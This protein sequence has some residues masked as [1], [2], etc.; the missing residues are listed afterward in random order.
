MIADLR[1]IVDEST[2]SAVVEY[3]QQLGYDVLFAG[4]IMARSD[5]SVILDLAVQQHRIVVT[6]DKDFG[7]L[8]FRSGKPHDGI[9]LLRLDDESPQN[10]LRVFQNV[11]R[12]YQE[13]LPGNFVVATEKGV[14]IRTLRNFL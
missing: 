11:L 9:L 4:D 12:L 3:L 2:G 6:N 7:E 14:R 13:R 5:D 10:R 1:F 8:V